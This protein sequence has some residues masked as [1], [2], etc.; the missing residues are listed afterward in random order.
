M[1]NRGATIKP[2]KQHPIRTTWLKNALSAVGSSSKAVLKEYAPTISGAVDSGAGLARMMNSTVRGTRRGAAGTNL[3]QNK[4][5]KLANTAFKNALDDIKSGH[6]AGNDSRMEK[7]LMGD[8]GFDD[9]FSGNDSGVSFGD[10]GGGGGNVTMNY[11]NAAGTAEAFT[12]LS[13]SINQQTEL[14]LR[15][16][17]AQTD[18]FVSMSS[19][20]FFQTQQIGGQ[21]LEQLG[22]INQN[23]ASLVE[24]SSSNMNKFIESSIAYYD[25]MGQVMTQRGSNSSDDDEEDDGSGLNSV[26]KSGGKFD[27]GAYS[28][29][30]KK[31]LK[32]NLSN[33]EFGMISELM[34]GDTLKYAA[35]NPLGFLSTSIV[36][37]AVPEVLTSTIN[38]VDEALSGMMPTMLKQLYDWGDQQSGTIFKKLTGTLAKSL[39]INLDRINY[40]DKKNDIK[41]NTDA[42]P[43]DGETKL[44][45]T[46][47]ITKELG[48]QT[49]YLKFIAEHINGEKKSDKYSAQ[50]KERMGDRQIFNYENNDYQS[51]RDFEKEILKSIQKGVVDGFKGTNLGK[52]IDAVIGSVESKESQDSLKSIANQY[53]QYLDSVSADKRVDLTSKNGRLNS[54][55]KGAIK[56]FAGNKDSI[57]MFIDMLEQMAA[58]DPTTLN[59]FTQGQVLATNNRNKKINELKKDPTKSGILQTDLFNRKGKD[60]KVI[61]IDTLLEEL[62]RQQAEDVN[63]K[64]IKKEKINYRDAINNDSFANGNTMK[65][66][67]RLR[68][69][70][71]ESGSR[72]GQALANGDSQALFAEVG[73]MIGG[74]ATTMMDT[75]DTKVLQPM[76]AKLIGTKDDNGFSRG[77]TL[78]SMTN[79]IKDSF[80]EMQHRFTGKAYIDSEG[81]KHD[82]SED[83][84]IATVKDG[85]ME[86]IFGKKDQE[87]GKRERQGIFSGITDSIKQ[88][89]A[90]WHNA[91]FGDTSKEGEQ[92][93]KDNVMQL[94]HKS[95][96]K[97]LPDAMVGGVAGGAAG[98]ASGGL[99]GAMIGGPIGGVILGSAVGFATNSDKFQKFIFGDQD[100]DNGLIT[101]KTQEFIKDNKGALIGGA[102]LG[103]LKG[104][105]TGG[106]FLGTLVGGPVA[107]AL[108]GM[109]TT[110][111][112][113]SQAFQ[114]FL[115]GDE[116]RGRI[117]IVTSIKNV[118]SHVKEKNKDAAG[119]TLSGKAVGMGATGAAAGALTAAT[120]AHIGF[121]P[122]MLT[123]AGPIGGAVVGLGLAIKAQSDTFSRWLFGNKKKKDDPEYQA[124][125]IGQLGNTLQAYVVQPFK[126]TVEEIATDM[127]LTFRHRI[128]GS[129]EN[130][131][132]PIGEAVADA[133]FWVKD[134]FKKGANFIGSFVKDNLMDPL[135]SVLKNTMIAPFATLGKNVAKLSYNVAKQAVLLPFRILDGVTHAIVSPI[136]KTLSKI[137]HPIKGAKWL[138]HTIA[139][140]FEKATGLSLDPV[141]KAMDWASSKMKKGLVGILT[142]PFKLVGGVV[143]GAAKGVGTAARM[144]DDFGER[145]NIKR[146]ER[147]G[148]FDDENLKKRYANE[149]RKKGKDGKLLDE[150]GDEISYTKYKANYMRSQNKDAY[151]YVE[152]LKNTYNR[153]NAQGRLTPNDKGELPSFE[154][155]KD[156]Y[157]RGDFKSRWEVQKVNEEADRAEAKVRAKRNRDR[158]RNQKNI[159]KYTGGS[160]W[161]D[162]VANRAMAEA[163]AGKK[164]KWRGEAV[165]E[166]D[167]KND[168]QKI[169]ETAKLSDAD[170]VS[171]DT[172]HMTNSAR[173]VSILQKIL[174]VIEGKNPD[175]SK[176]DYGMG[177][178]G[179]PYKYGEDN[180]NPEVE[181]SKSDTPV[182]PVT[183]NFSLF[184]SN[185]SDAD[186]YEVN[187]AGIDNSKTAAAFASILNNTSGEG[188]A[189][190]TDDAKEGYSLVGEAGR[191]EIVWTNKGDKVYS[192][193]NKPIRV[194]VADFARSAVSKFMKFM[195]GES[196]QDAGVGGANNAIP[197][198]NIARAALSGPIAG[199]SPLGLP[200]PTESDA[201]IAANAYSQID[202]GEEAENNATIGVSGM[203]GLPLSILNDNNSEEGSQTDIQL[204]SADVLSNTQVAI[205]KGKQELRDKTMDA[206]LT[207]DEAMA[208]KA[209][210]KKEGRMNRILDAVEGMAGKTK[211]QVKK[212]GS[213]FKEWTSMFG[214]KGL[215]GAGLITLLAFLNKSG[216]LKKL[217]DLI[218]GTAGSV[219]GAVGDAFSSASSDAQWQDENRAN[220][221]G[222]SGAEEGQGFLND[223]RELLSGDISGYL[224]NDEGETD[225]ATYAKGKLLYKVAK[226]PVQALYRLGKGIVKGG[227]KVVKGL[228]KGAGWVIRNT[229]GRTR[230]GKGISGAV[231]GIKG[232]Y[233]AGKEMGNAMGHIASGNMPIENMSSFDGLASNGYTLGSESYVLPSE[234]PDW[235]ASMGG[236]ADNVAENV[237]SDVGATFSSTAGNVVAEEV[238]DAEFNAALK[239]SGG[240]ASNIIIDSTGSIIDDTIPQ[241]PG[242][243]LESAAGAA[244]NVVEATMKS[245]AD[246][247]VEAGAKG[248]AGATDNI[249]EA[250]MRSQADDVVEGGS[251]LILESAENTVEK[252]NGKLKSKI[253]DM[254]KSFFTKVGQKVGKSESKLADSWIGKI[255]SKITKAFSSEGIFGKIASKVSSIMGAKT[256]IAG[257]TLGVS[258]VVFLT[259]GALN[260]VTGT[261]RLFQVNKN[262][263]DNTMRVIS[264]A[265]GAF[266]STTVGSVVDV[267]NEVISATCGFDILNTAACM[268]YELIKGKESYDELQDDR[269]AFKDEYIDDRN[270]ELTKQYETL[271]EAGLTEGKYDDA[272]AYIAAVEN[273]EVNG[274]YESFQDYNSDKNASLMEKGTKKVV[275]TAK[276]VGKT[277]SNWWNGKDESRDGYFGATGNKYLKNDDGSYTIYD[278]E[279]NELGTVGD[280]SNF[281][282]DI[283]GTYHQAGKQTKGAKQT[284]VKMGKKLASAANTLKKGIGTAVDAVVSNVSKF[285]SAI[286][287]AAKSTWDFF[288]KKETRTDTVYELNDG[289]GQY[290]DMDGQLYNVNGDKIGDPIGSTELGSLYRSGLVSEAKHE[291]VI[292]GTGFEKWKDAT[293][294]KIKQGFASLKDKAGEV[295]S[296]IGSAVSDFGSKAVELGG[297]VVKAGKGVWDFFTKRK[298][299]LKSVWMLNDG[300]GR[301][302]DDTGVLYNADGDKTDE[303]ISAEDLSA[304]ISG[305]LVTHSE[306]ESKT[307]YEKWTESTISKIKDTFKNINDKAR[308]VGAKIVD[309]GKAWVDKAGKKLT[310]LKNTAAKIV[311][312]GISFVK[313]HKAGKWVDSDGSYYEQSSM[314]GSEWYHYSSSG[315]KLSDETFT[316]DEMEVLSSSGALHYTEEWTN[317]ANEMWDHQILPALKEGKDKVVS[318]VSSGFKSV[319]TFMGNAASWTVDKFKKYDNWT[320]RN[321]KR[322]KSL[323]SSTTE[324]RYMDS[325]GSYY[326]AATHGYTHY[327]SSG[328]IIEDN[329]DADEIDPLIEA[330][331]LHS[332]DHT[333][334]AKIKQVWE[335]TI[336]P[337]FKSA[338]NKVQDTFKTGYE[339]VADFTSKVTDA[340]KEKYDRWRNWQH[341]N[342]EK[343][344][345]FFSGKTETRYMAPD[346]TYY[347]AAGEKFIHYS[348]LGDVIDDDCDLEDTLAMIE[349]GTLKEVEYT[350]PSGVAKIGNNIKENATKAVNFFKDGASAVQQGLETFGA[351]ISSF[352]SNVQKYGLLHTITGAFKKQTS[353]GYFEPTGNYYKRNGT[354][355]D[356]YSQ[357]GDLIESGVSDEEID[358]KIQAGLVTPHEITEDS[359]A[360]K[361]I[362][363]IQKSAKNAW[364]K[365]KNVVTS[366]WAKFTNWLTGGS[367]KGSPKSRGSGG[368][369]GYTIADFDDKTYGELPQF[370]DV[371]A[372]GSG[373][374]PKSNVFQRAIAMR[375]ARDHGFGSGPRRKRRRRSGGGFGK[376]GNAAPD[377]V[378]GHS[379]YAQTDKRWANDSYEYDGDGGTLGDSGCG[380]AAMSMVVADMAGTNVDPRKMAV[381]AE[382]TGTRDHTGTNWNFVAGAADTF[383]LQ[384]EQRYNPS[385]KF[386]SDSLRSGNEV[387]LSGTSNGKN[388][389]YTNAG[390]YV[391]AV[392]QDSNGK[393]RV[394]DPRGKSYSRSYTPEELVPYTGSAW[395]IGNGGSGGRHKGYSLFNK[396]SGGRGKD[397]NKNDQ[398]TTGTTSSSSSN[399]NSNN[400]SN[401]NSASAASD[402]D[403]LNGFP[404]LLQSD[405]RWGSNPYTSIGD[406]SQTIASSA[407]GPTSMAIILRSFG[408]DITPVETCQYALDNGYRT[409]NS[410]T[411]W[412]F[413]PSIGNKY[414]ITTEELGV[415]GDAIEKSLKDSKAIIGSM[416]PGTFTQGGHFIDLVGLKDGKVVVNDCASRD[417]SMKTYP[418]STFTSEGNNYWA[419]SKDGKG[420]IGNVASA[421]SASS[422]SSSGGSVSDGTVLD[423]IGSFFSEVGNRAIEG[424]LTGNWNTDFTSFWNPSTGTDTSSTSSTTTTTPTN[425]GNLQGNDTTEQVYNYLTT[426]GGMTPY[427]AAGLMGNLEA[428]S[429]INPGIVEGLLAQKLGTTSAQYTSD[430]D[431][432]KI[433]KEQ[434]LHPL[435]GNSQY[436][437][438]LA[439]WTS[440]GRKQGLYDLVKS[441]NVS[442]ADTKAQLDWLLQELQS[443]SYSSVLSTL[444]SATSVSEASNVVLHKFEA[445]ADQSSAVEQKRA[446]MG[447]AWYNK[448]AA[449]SGSKGGFGVRFL[450][451][452]NKIMGG[453]GG[454]N[455]ILESINKQRGGKGSTAADAREA[456]VNW[457]MTIVE[458][459]TYTQS[460]DRSRVMEGV[461][462]H[463]YGDCSSTCC[464]IYETALGMTIGSYTGDMIP[465]GTVVDGP[466]TSMGTYPDESKLLPGDLVFF[467]SHGSSGQEGHVEMYIGNGMLCGHGGSNDPGPRI[468]DIK[469]YTDGRVSSGYGTW[470]QV[471]RYVQDGQT[472][473]VTQPD[474]SKMKKQNTYTDGKG[475]SANGANTGASNTTSSTTSDGTTTTT[476]GQEGNSTIDKIGNFFGEVANRA[477]EGTLT[478]NWNL[479]F[480]SFWN[481]TTTTTSSGDSS[482][483]SSSVIPGSFPKYTFTDDQKKY[484]AQIMMRENGGENLAIT[485]DGA[486]HMANLSEVQFNHPA[487]AESLVDM[488][489]TSGWFGSGGGSIPAYAQNPNQNVYDAI[490]QVLEQGNRTL[491]RYVTEYDM[492]PLDAAL[493]GHWYN[494]RNGENQSDYVKHKTL[495]TQNASRGLDAKYTFYKFFG[496][497]CRVGDV[498]GYYEQYYQK[499]KDDDPRPDG[500]TPDPGGSGEGAP[501]R[502]DDQRTLN[503]IHIIG[504]QGDK[505]GFGFNDA[506][507][508]TSDVDPKNIT[509]TPQ[510]YAPSKAVIDSRMKARAKLSQKRSEAYQKYLDK[511]NKKNGGHGGGRG[512]VATSNA[513]YINANSTSYSGTE[514]TSTSTLSEIMSR[515]DS[516]KAN[517]NES[518]LLHCMIEILAIIADNTGKSVSGLTQANELLANLKTGGNNVI[519]NKSSDTPVTN[520][521]RQEGSK[522]TKNMKL[523]QQIAA[524]K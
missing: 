479:D 161:E 208:A 281:E 302:Y 438:G 391:V 397:D 191:P 291:T 388:T 38:G 205:V 457:M 325:D 31:R 480:N 429:G 46:N 34:G 15:T 45:I 483:G 115:F 122:A 210:E 463:G 494:G 196:T 82:K 374:G 274:K 235:Y 367:G 283:V 204:P 327:N 305:G 173:Q 221:N 288:T 261:A 484:I 443:S 195:K 185:N 363:E 477:M 169:D 287:G 146:M 524:G 487:T 258:E 316:D 137:F 395:S 436:G 387:V 223:I 375:Q 295:A 234:Q 339:A 284:V 54:Q 237:G 268:I 451:N 154:E 338:V 298:T 194:M 212:T 333:E 444:K 92:V 427:G 149:I 263:V 417:R 6:L 217:L 331:M 350:E 393:I 246:D 297:K 337:G 478:G 2:I 104:A 83:S 322:L 180:K 63:N 117:G 413:F 276:G 440:P 43:F 368:G 399:T 267:V 74:A 356:Y 343:I 183:G 32:S 382:E 13:S 249:I 392:G 129:I 404:Y 37:W 151:N 130:A 299:E 419:F 160:Q 49:V 342:V 454:I 168:P 418:I 309:T 365:A 522:P 492:F 202:A 332:V 324:T 286:G 10:E 446:S 351:S 94:M 358:A 100:K 272:D 431:S 364:E 178:K 381:L 328:D 239:G 409:A 8:G 4:Y 142:S 518:E 162:T 371:S 408:V 114:D 432:G 336:V 389:P 76:K 118:F 486:S 264:A 513:G 156:N 362:D 307:G 241:L 97:K 469:T 384:S 222:K 407:C 315:E 385:T 103:G 126:H 155:W 501:A 12:S 460:G 318:A 493:S 14:T 304:L 396:K 24:Y 273:G 245:S 72:L 495:I 25:K 108:L 73:N 145:Q 88:S 416:G 515:S 18:A 186:S 227:A 139:T 290:Y 257:V 121:M 131:I 340:A 152:K 27:F 506:N 301:F 110:T 171:A 456:L 21:M 452:L 120:L 449:A 135:V 359:T 39:G 48:E 348:K 517:K 300:T 96:Q 198:G 476:G 187:G 36:K 214:K 423:K 398:N 406:S 159:V 124:G 65:L 3:A 199:S 335:N 369:F 170:L 80:L 311:G 455:K 280:E 250:T 462:G 507:T 425:S 93:T 98:L 44:A 59:S 193:K 459:N 489:K 497:D 189:D 394:N 70:G 134:K 512:V 402:A 225:H 412:D 52:S 229:L 317:G 242:P 439:Q 157:V 352:M 420:S 252:S 172:K 294:Q 16:S 81:K 140:S 380:P 85:I 233:S 71:M 520:K 106:G 468:H 209:E 514:Y 516:A 403:M 125:V 127:S 163:R 230:L 435:G 42:I 349:N 266:T 5:V 471:N 360:K 372:G 329:V 502:L 310:A 182:P 269:A 40:I 260:G 240:N 326:V 405:P 334:E 450:R 434:F 226:K 201:R 113:K 330:G 203:S 430:V 259:L 270:K 123:A 244:D 475:N 231:N 519:V 22:A 461:D 386:I 109:A 320:G 383:G 248:V 485:K 190:G 177:D 458:R 197:G 95:L 30:V 521:L 243:T 218:G 119:L 102:A 33:S 379:Y 510:V 289:S 314:G 361:A 247:V 296:K 164:L 377:T 9:L 447:Q 373:A 51:M 57:N 167:I 275:D 271:K 313:W 312:K 370:A 99:L 56:G 236:A 508:F 111:A 376:A 133:A 192:D 90:D 523:A 401:T 75:F 175:G 228:G 421:G 504:S 213:F 466:N 132:E 292:G 441:R 17:K 206:A 265:F 442:I 78:S 176:K 345:E 414:G 105:I 23:L 353:M 50:L 319:Q 128:L 490:T 188:Y 184:G 143:S 410:G 11:V 35:A 47:T 308:E 341:G 61:P 66:L 293:G 470:V 467:Y 448:Y 87:S 68:K 84:I 482:T 224:T 346:E 55:L 150:N 344:K 53:Y 433:T 220:T 238:T 29:Y 251:K 424:T 500:V 79:M 138:M 499:Y 491:P 355:W 473:N 147:G 67:E 354:S 282:D 19:A 181:G 112:L 101:K 277:I 179:K 158:D 357:T 474:K 1:A 428:E 211:E 28:K 116:E 89:F 77:G 166:N 86:K 262:K 411:S 69:N 165:D 503:K 20:Q 153:L 426:S 303:S 253:I 445:P 306:F 511:V 207:A 509:V 422:G 481:G 400:S 255:M 366:G 465:N 60:G 216:I 498:S 58:N 141:R 285:G 321:R 464:K 107:G 254:L 472:Y 64:D 174:N 323:V 347:M 232:A 136:R 219:A 256:T 378:N 415:S 144:V 26:I 148:K 215:I 278:K 200:G 91:M 496:D 437:Y 390:H 7:V 488:I 62:V 453:K 41:I 279:G 505:G